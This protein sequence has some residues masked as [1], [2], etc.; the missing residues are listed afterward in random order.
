[1]LTLKAVIRKSLRVG[2]TVTQFEGIANISGIVTKAIWAPQDAAQGGPELVGVA[3]AAVPP[4]GAT[5]PTSEVEIELL[6][7]FRAGIYSTQN[8]VLLVFFECR[9]S[10]A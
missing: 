8:K 5:L 3:A 10:C 1:M 9:F 6:P 2:D 4:G 7:K